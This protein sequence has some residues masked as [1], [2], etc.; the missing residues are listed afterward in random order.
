MRN[1]AQDV[2]S[3]IYFEKKSLKLDGK[4]VPRKINAYFA[5]FTY[6]PYKISKGSH[7]HTHLKWLTRRSIEIVKFLGHEVDRSEVIN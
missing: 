5:L 7:I 3:V 1:I 2:S 4:I 6:F